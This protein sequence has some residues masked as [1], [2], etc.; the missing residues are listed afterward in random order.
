MG[1]HHRTPFG[2]GARNLKIVNLYDLTLNE[3]ATLLA[4]LGEPR[5]RADQLWR[6]L[7]C[8]LANDFEAMT[9]LPKTLRARLAETAQID[10]LRLVTATESSDRSAC[11]LLFALPDEQTIESVLMHYADEA[12]D[13]QDFQNSAGKQTPPTVERHTVCVSTQAGCALGCVFCATGQMGLVRNLTPG[14]IIGQVLYCERLLRPP[15]KKLTNVVF[16]GMGEPLANFDAT[17]QAVETLHHP[18]GFNLG[19]RRMTISTVGLVPGIRKLIARQLPVNLAVSLHAPNDVLRNRLVPVNTRYPISELLEVCRN[20]VAETGRRLTIEYV[21]IDGVNDSPDL[22]QE[23]ASLLQGLL[24]HVNLIPV[25]PTTATEYRPSPAYVARAFRDILQRAGIQTTLR[26]RRGIDIQ[27]GCGQLRTQVRPT[28][29]TSIN[30][31]VTVGTTAVGTAVQRSSP[32][33]LTK[34]GEQ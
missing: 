17:W 2:M 22:A 7:Y 21:L 27:A 14:E 16:M 33:L 8:D 10:P 3:I 5:Y 19:A 11:K 18:Q 20:Y 34:Q 1:S 4:Q 28:R 30:R 23:L 25:N 32:L 6:W 24:V 26:L 15:G 29:A 9:N 12:A 13:T 31:S